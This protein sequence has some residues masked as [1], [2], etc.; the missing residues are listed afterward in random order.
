MRPES[1][2]LRRLLASRSRPKNGSVARN[3]RGPTY[4]LLGPAP[5]IVPVARDLVIDGPAL[6]ELP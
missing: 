2:V 5:V 1:R 4:G 3:G 6:V